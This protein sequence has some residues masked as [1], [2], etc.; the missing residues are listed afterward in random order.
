MKSLIGGVAALLLATTTTAL[1]Q[2]TPL[3]SGDP[4]NSPTG[5]PSSPTP[6]VPSAAAAEAPIGPQLVQR[7][8]QWW[9]GD[10]K[11]TNIEIA[12]YK[13]ANSQPPR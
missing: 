2:S 7:N 1:A 13:A 6:P 10:R 12:Q 11:A 8:G 3:P 4:M 5:T 9:N